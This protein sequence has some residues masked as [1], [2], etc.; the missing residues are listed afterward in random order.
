MRELRLFNIHYNYTF[1]G[2][3]ICEKNR[4]ILITLIT[5]VRLINKVSAMYHQFLASTV[6]RTSNS[7]FYNL[8]RLKILIH[9]ER[10]MQGGFVHSLMNRTQTEHVHL[11][12]SGIKEK[13]GCSESQ[14]Q[15][16]MQKLCHTTPLLTLLC[17]F[18]CPSDIHPCRG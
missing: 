10:A 15:R 17:R 12:Q 2:I 6:N 8:P 16:A 1:G 13:G 9:A 14:A 11:I 5:C 7:Y 18:T 4:H 3:L